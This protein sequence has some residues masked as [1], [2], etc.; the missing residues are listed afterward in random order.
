MGTN[1]AIYASNKEMAQAATCQ[2]I[3]MGASLFTKRTCCTPL[4]PGVS[5]IT[6][7]HATCSGLPCMGR[8]STRSRTTMGARHP[9]S[10]PFHRPYVLKPHS[11]R[12]GCSSFNTSPAL[13]AGSGPRTH[14]IPTRFHKPCLTASK[15]QVASTP[16]HAPEYCML[17]AYA[18]PAHHYAV[19]P[20]AAAPAAA[21]TAGGSCP[22]GSTPCVLTP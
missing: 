9:K 14:L 17:A 5:P 8:L 15:L 6:C 1:R 19:A 2:A 3:A 11:S 10:N 18:T 12:H 21:A 20:A 22:S 13:M 7:A 4:L 16:Q